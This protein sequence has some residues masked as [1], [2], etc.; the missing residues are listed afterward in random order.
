MLRAAALFCEKPLVVVVRADPNLRDRIAFERA[1][2]TVLDTDTSR[3]QR[4]FV[5]HPLELEAGM[6][7][8]VSELGVGSLRTFLDP[9]G[10]R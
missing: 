4:F 3:I 7:R 5:G 6:T 9:S 1:D 10:K 2:S 8:I